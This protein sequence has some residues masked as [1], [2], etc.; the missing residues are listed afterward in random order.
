MHLIDESWNRRESTPYCEVWISYYTLETITQL[1]K[2]T[3]I[4]ESWN[5]GT[6]TTA[7]KLCK[8][9]YW[10]DVDGFNNDSERCDNNKHDGDYAGYHLRK[11]D[12]HHA[13]G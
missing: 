9:E 12:S 11:H 7:I 3:Q 13:G 1:P 5:L 6:T 8:P 4:C 2:C 10:Y